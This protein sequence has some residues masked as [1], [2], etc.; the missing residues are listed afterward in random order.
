MAMWMG[1]LEFDVLLGD[2]H[3]LK[4]KRSVVRPLIAEVRR[5]FE[6]S[7]AEVDHLELHRRA[8]IGVAAV[9][10]DRTH[11]V[12]VLDAVEQLVASR[13]EVELLSVHRTLRAAGD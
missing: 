9:S 12:E 11:L 8:A 7:V 4:E 2:V 1:A 5:R 10:P 3:S 13:P 6:L